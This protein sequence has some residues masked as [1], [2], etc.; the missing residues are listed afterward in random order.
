MFIKASVLLSKVIVFYKIRSLIKQIFDLLT[1]SY[2]LP[3][4]FMN[5][6]IH[7][8]E[9]RWNIFRTYKY[10]IYKEYIRNIHKYS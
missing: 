10:E 1:K 4:K 9:N 2:V 6:K 3:G 7:T 5:F 8:K